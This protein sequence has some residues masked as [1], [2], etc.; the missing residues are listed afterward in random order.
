MNSTHSR[1]RAGLPTVRGDRPQSQ[2]IAIPCLNAQ[3]TIRNGT[4]SDNPAVNTGAANHSRVTL[5]A[6]T[7][8]VKRATPGSEDSNHSGTTDSASTY[9]AESIQ[10]TPFLRTHATTEKGPRFSDAYARR[11][12]TSIRG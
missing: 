6:A 4:S 11:S 2:A 5:A 1:H 12:A 10:S 8:S 9:P 3:A 7:F